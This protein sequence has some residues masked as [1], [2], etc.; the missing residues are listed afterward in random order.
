MQIVKELKVPDQ[1]VRDTL[2]LDLL[3]NKGYSR[4]RP[5]RLDKYSNRFKRNLIF[6]IRKNPKASYTKIRK[7]F[8]FKIS[9]KTIN[10]ILD[11][12]GIYYQRCKKRPFLIEEVAAKRLAQYL[13]RKD[14][15]QID[16]YKY[17]QSNECS[18]K[19]RAS[20]A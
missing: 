4:P 2:K 1:T 20:R 11:T 18:A 13:A 5:S 19:R 17:I 12:I 10:R 8:K 3:C 15:T 7:H 16:F 9:N 6:F 14:Q